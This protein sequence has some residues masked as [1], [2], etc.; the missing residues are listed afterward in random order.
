[1]DPD[2][3]SQGS[4]WTGTFF[5]ASIVVLAA[6]LWIMTRSSGPPS[7]Q[8]N[9][10]LS[11]RPV[12]EFHCAPRGTGPYPV[13][14]MLHGAAMRG[15]ADDEFHAMC[16]KLANHGYY[17]QFIEYYDATENS[18]S[19]IDASENFEAWFGAIGAALD[20]LDK[21][22]AVDPKRIALMGFSQGAYLAMGA[23]AMFPKQVAAVAEYYGGLIPHLR[24]RAKLMPPTLIIHGGRDSII[25]L[26]EA[27][28]LDKLLTAAGRSHEIHIYPQA[29]HGFNFHSDGLRYD[30]DAADDAW[31]RSLKFLDR[32][33]QRSDLPK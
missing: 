25:P 30:K 1:L 17:G 6:V 20:A 29:D 24:D 22:P 8:G 23:G 21:N 5:K 16:L 14:I 31:D 7:I 19:T 12:G 18:D 28:D 33:F 3:N 9:L 32:T 13:V 15:T 27:T 2:N 26:S 11:G 4:S 10:Q